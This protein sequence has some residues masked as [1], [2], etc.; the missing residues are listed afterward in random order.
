MAS[1]DLLLTLTGPAT[2][3]AGASVGV[4]LSIRNNGP[5]KANGAKL[6]I[7]VSAGLIKVK[8]V[9]AN[10]AGGARCPTSIPS[11]GNVSVK[12]PTLPA[13]GSFTATVTGT[14]GTP[15]NSPIAF[16][17][18]VLP[19]APATDPTPANA[20]A[21]LSITIVAVLD[22]VVRRFLADPSTVTPGQEDSERVPATWFGNQVDPLIDGSEYFLALRRETDTLLA[23]ATGTRP[24]FYFA[25]WLLERFLIR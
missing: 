23:A 6:I 20:T 12:I 1:T 15:G 16:D 24:F 11:G 5:D 14:A 2:V 18:Q 17:A 19:P 3:R 9:C 25:N 10:A 8:T 4:T 7:V 13:G 22:F 21:S